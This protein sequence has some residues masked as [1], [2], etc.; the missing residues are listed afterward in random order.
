MNPEISNLPEGTLLLIRHGI[1]EDPRPGA[2]DAERSLTEEGWKK[3]RAAMRG[4]VKSGWIPAAAFSSPYRRAA[5]TL[6][7]L[8]EAVLK[9]GLKAF[10]A[11]SWE[12]CVPEGDPRSAEVWLLKKLA[13]AKPGTTLA[14][15]SH[16]PFLGELIFRL[17]GEN[18]EIRKG[19]C[20]VV[21][22][23]D[24]AWSLLEHYR[25]AELRGKA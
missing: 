8:T 16:Q 23:K 24:G 3:T 6:S 18:L 9:A 5:E 14:V 4:L 15:V 21:E 25:P 7:C 13:A 19:S 17:T 20:T 11:G 22:R 2:R 12:G 1:A 10:P